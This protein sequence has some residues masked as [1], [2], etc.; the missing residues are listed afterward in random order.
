MQ[1][2]LSKAH[3]ELCCKLCQNALHAIP[4]CPPPTKKNH[5]WH[6]WSRQYLAISSA[7]VG[8]E[9]DAVGGLIMKSLGAEVTVISD[10]LDVRPSAGVPISVAG[11]I[12][13][14]KPFGRIHRLAE[15]C[16]KAIVLALISN[17]HRRRRVY[18][19]ARKLSND[20]DQSSDFEPSGPGRHP[21]SRV[22]M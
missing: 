4:A 16:C 6:A 19:H 5:S 11:L 22:R 14:N 18:G 20:E 13:E 17:L 7:L 10:Q 8:S 12:L 9:H 3:L 15:L 21:S 1:S 2:N